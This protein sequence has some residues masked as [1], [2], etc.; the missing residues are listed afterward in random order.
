MV[1]CSIMCLW[2]DQEY[3]ALSGDFRHAPP[4]DA[5]C[6]KIPKIPK[7]SFFIRGVGVVPGF[8]M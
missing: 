1:V 2:I 3:R 7:K 4:L 6:S 8:T 5:V